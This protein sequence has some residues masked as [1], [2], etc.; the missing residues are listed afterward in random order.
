M[1]PSLPR[2]SFFFLR[3][4][5][6]DHNR[7]RLVMG[8][9]DIPL[10]AEGRRQAENAANLLKEHGIRSIASSP[11]SRALE[12]A[13][14]VAEIIGADITIIE[15]LQER[16]WGSLTGRSH[17]ELFRL[18]PS[19]TPDGAETGAEFTE[20]IIKA[21]ADLTQPEPVLI[22]AHAGACR[23]LRRVMRLDDGESPVPNA[24]PLEF[25]AEENGGWR[26]RRVV[27]PPQP[28]PSKEGGGPI[29]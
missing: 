21:L 6:T 28:S 5:V 18:P 1:H 14:I 27:R 17:Q 11:L 3:H 29:H 16:A 2:S 23:V 15:D 22:V 7:A 20:R 13:R 8:Q 4:G 9:L 10:N 24:T 12:T 25:I 26:E 19:I